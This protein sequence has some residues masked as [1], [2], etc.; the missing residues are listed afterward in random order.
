MISPHVFEI[1]VNFDEQYT[2]MTSL[3]SVQQEWIPRARGR[4]SALGGFMS[5]VHPTG[6]SY[7]FYYTEQNKT[8]K[9]EK[10]QTP[11]I[12]DTYSFS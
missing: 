5:V 7:L 1:G 2:I 10:W 4:Q 12:M 11:E 3:W 9:G 6:R 8:Q